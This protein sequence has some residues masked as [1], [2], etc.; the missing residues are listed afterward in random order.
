MTFYSKVLS[1]HVPE[2]SVRHGG[3]TLFET[4]GFKWQAGGTFSQQY[5]V[6]YMITVDFFKFLCR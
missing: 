1:N 4:I 6:V 2:D 3:Q 5:S